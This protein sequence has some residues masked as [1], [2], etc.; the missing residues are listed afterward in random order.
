MSVE[1]TNWS[2]L[3]QSRPAEVRPVNTVADVQSAV[4]HAGIHGWAI[5]TAGS[6]HSHSDLLRIDGGLVLLTDGIVGRP[7]T[8]TT[9]RTAKIAAGMKLKDVGEPLW[10]A[11]LSFTNQG[12]VDV[13]SVAGLVG[14]GVHGTGTTL[15]S[16]SASVRAATIVTATGDVV[17]TDNDP[18]LLEAA[19][20]NLGALGVVV[21]VSFEL[22]PA[23]HL[24]ER[25]SVESLEGVLERIDELTSTTRHF[26]FFW[27]PITDKA[28]AKALHPH[29][30][31]PDP[32]AD[33]PKER[34]DRAYRVFPS[35]R[36]D[37]HTEMEYSVPS[38]LG[39][40]CFRAIRALMRSQFP[41]VAWPAEYRTVAA[42]SGWISP[43]RGRAT[44][45]ISVHQGIGL[46]FEEFFAASEKIFREH[47]GRP[48]WG[49]CHSLTAA[50]FAAEHPDTW[51]RFWGVQR[52]LDPKGRFLNSHL[53][54]IAGR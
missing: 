9:A 13:Q 28:Y 14:T 37:K 4:A 29:P 32:L 40:S 35:I 26:E 48:H 53:H 21:D 1:F 51:D 8:D 3:V 25:T 45:A 27:Y 31:P 33:Q 47:R 18:D 41:D 49:K 46:P 43:A 52:R 22:T 16:V 54:T 10:D 7:A 30:G 2:G 15:S 34:I 5:R 20:L 23:Y 42:D 50:D 39:P 36:D 38:E 24:H 11:G 12:D 19:R 17:T 44:V 6:T